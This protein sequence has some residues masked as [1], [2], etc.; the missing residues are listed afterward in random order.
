MDN[1]TEGF[2][3]YHVPC[4]KCGSSDARSVNADGSSYCFSCNNYFRAEEQGQINN[5]GGDFDKG[6]EIN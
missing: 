6:F 1:K 3:E 2:V 4:L 5:E